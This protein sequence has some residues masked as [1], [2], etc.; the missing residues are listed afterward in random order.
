VRAIE[1]PELVKRL[2]ER[3]IPLG[4]CPSSNLTLGLYKT[5]GEHPIDRLRRAGVP[6]S[7]N[8]DD[9]EL[10]RIDLAGEY[11]RCA[12]AFGWDAQ[13]CREVAST[14]VRASFAGESQQTAWLAQ[15]G[16]W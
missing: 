12:E 13:T 14:S 11:R 2:A 16:T 5:L 1:D 8:T 15:I 3:Q 7:V 9:P 4:I 6:V 10:L